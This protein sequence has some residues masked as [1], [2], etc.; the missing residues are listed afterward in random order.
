MDRTWARWRWMV[1][2]TAL[3][4][5][6]A[7]LIWSRVW[8][9]GHP[10]GMTTCACG[11]PGQGIWSLGWMP[12][13]LGHGLDPFVSGY[14]FAPDGIN[15]LDNTSSLLPAFVLSPVTV[16]FGPIVSLNVALTLAPVVNAC[17]AYAAVRRFTGWRPAA[18]AGGLL[19]GFSPFV[20]TSS[21]VGHLQFAVLFVP[22]LLLIVLYETLVG[23]EWSPRRSAVSVWVLLVAQFFIGTEMLAITVMVAVIGLVVLACAYP[24]KVVPV[25]RRAA[26][27]LL[28]GAGGALVVLAWPMWMVVDGPRHFTGVQH[29]G[30]AFAGV[31]FRSIVDPGAAATRPSAIGAFIGYVGAQGPSVLY[32][33]IAMAVL[34]V[35]GVVALRRQAVVRWCAGM[36]VITVL[37]AGGVVFGD[38]FLAKPSW[39]A[40]WRIV[41]KLPLLGEAGPSHVAGI[42]MLFVGILFGMVLDRG[43]AFGR[44]RLR[45]YRRGSMVSTYCRPLAGSAVALVAVVALAPI[46][47]SL[48]LPATVQ[49]VVPPTGFDQV[50]ASTPPATTMLLFPFPSTYDDE[51]LVWQAQSGFAFKVNGGYGFVPG[52]G[53]A[54]LSA[55]DTSTGYGV[56]ASLNVGPLSGPMAQQLR[57][58]RDDAV[59]A[60]VT[61][62]VV[63]PR[64]PGGLYFYALAFYTAL[65][66]RGP[67]Y[68]RGGDWVWQGA[69]TERPPLVVANAVVS[70]CSLLGS[71]PGRPLAVPD[72]VLSAAGPGG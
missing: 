13:A 32:V 60:G 27:P 61:E 65:L 51:P 3:Y 41:D 47:G 33:G 22:P 12:F 10:A 29:A 57:L 25:I 53:R 69:V 44:Q 45:S 70:Y 28:Y 71:P 56:L 24:S 63:V 23:T 72:C 5:V 8:F 48:G 26:R 68:D 20:L 21:F 30:I 39:L 49:A 6:V 59:R 1:G 2:I 18:F 34:V 37:L 66:G 17:C 9:G 36:T 35:L 50:L 15:L 38:D 19:Y 4:L 31:S 14:L 40:P 7:V 46:A 64:G 11:D 55:T 16:L 52:P 42:T 62:T 43:Y 54:R 67:A 58:A